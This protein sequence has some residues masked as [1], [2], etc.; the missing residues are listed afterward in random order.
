MGTILAKAKEMI[1]GKPAPVC[2]YTSE[3]GGWSKFDNDVRLLLDEQK[4]EARVN[5][6]KAV[7]LEKEAEWQRGEISERARGIAHDEW[8][9]A[10]NVFAQISQAKLDLFRD[11]INSEERT[12]LRRLADRRYRVYI[13][14]SELQTQV[15]PLEREIQRREDHIIAQQAS[16]EAD[17]PV[18]LREIENERVK[19]ADLRRQL[20][21]LNDDLAGRQREFAEIDQGVEDLRQ[22]LFARLRE[23]HGGKAAK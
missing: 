17:H 23:E 4:L 9:N 20:V 14:Q 13:A 3:R 8:S 11:G 7:M 15:E 1:V 16:S 19:I 6:L 2:P 10:Y 18:V 5:E 21:D 22:S 12:Q